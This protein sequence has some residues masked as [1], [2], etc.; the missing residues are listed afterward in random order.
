VLLLSEC[1]I[2]V[3]VF[4]VDSVRKL[5]DTPSY[6]GAKVP[7]KRNGKT[8]RILHLGIT[9]G[10]EFPVLFRT[11][12][13]MVTRRT[14]EGED[15]YVGNR[16]PSCHFHETEGSNSLYTMGSIRHV[17]RGFKSK[18]NW[19]QM[20]DSSLQISWTGGSAPLLCFYV[21]ICITAAP[22]RQSMN[23]PNGPRSCS[24]TLQMFLLKR[25]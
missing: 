20:Y 9:S 22:C 19:L 3:L 18:F 4:V 17:F 24:A 8:Q 6:I 12:S 23:F 11:G 2:N 16:N 10:I 5:L 21:S 25:P 15:S 13:K 7:V 14:S 1:F